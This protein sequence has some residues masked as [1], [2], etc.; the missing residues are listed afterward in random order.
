MSKAPPHI[1]TAARRWAAQSPWLVLYTLTLSGQF[2]AAAAR[3]FITVIVLWIVS[4]LT[5][6]TMPINTIATV[7]AFAPLAVSL[8][9]I[10]CPPLIAPIDGRWWEMSSGGRP[11]EQDE[12]DAFM[13]AFTELQQFDP[14]LRA[15]RHWFVAEEPTHNAAAYS[16]SLRIDRG[17]LESPYAAAVIAHEMGH[18]R[19]S[20]AKVSS[21]LNLL[22][23][24]PMDTPPL[25]PAWS[26]PLR[27][28]LWLAS[29]QA[30]ISI[31]ANAWE[32]YWRSREFAADEYAIHLGQGPVLAESL[33]EDS[34]PYETTIPNMRFS[35]ATHPYTKPRIARL[36]THPTPTQEG[37]H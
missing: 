13:H 5:G 37:E 1:T 23:L 36:R 4:L 6:W 32:M 15:P 27:G 33:C 21:A 22:L 31:M 35:R 17:L 24:K 8:L 16:S 20:D 18:L 34:L 28:L 14:R 9:S 11:P 19:S 12:Q 7:I 30:V 29:G 3:G 2:L 26:L 10:L 25:R